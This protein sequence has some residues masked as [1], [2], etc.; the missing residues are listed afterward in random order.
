MTSSGLQDMSSECLLDMSSKRPQDMSSR[1]LQCNNFSSSKTSSRYL[2]DVLEDKNCYAEDVLK[3][4]SRH[5]FKISWRLDVSCHV[6]LCLHTCSVYSE[7]TLLSQLLFSLI[8]VPKFVC[9]DKPFV[10]FCAL[11]FHK[12]SQGQYIVYLNMQWLYLLRSQKD[13]QG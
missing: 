13:F 3:T 12:V 1:R 10:D 8:A 11:N 4:S 6:I 5:V 9:R 2:Q 7:D